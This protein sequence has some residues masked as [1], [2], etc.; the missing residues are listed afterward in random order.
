MN[1]LTRQIK[2]P[3]RKKSKSPYRKAHD[4]AWKEF[5]KFIR[6]RDPFCYTCGAPTTQAGHLFHNKL[7]FFE[8]NVHGQCTRCNHFLSGNLGEYTARFIEEAGLEAYQYL[9]WQSDQ[10]DK[11]SIPDLES[12]YQRYKKLNS[13]RR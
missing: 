5:S 11:L 4:K 13:A 12:I 7:D 10:V 3:I 9:K 6:N 1:L 8:S 2:K